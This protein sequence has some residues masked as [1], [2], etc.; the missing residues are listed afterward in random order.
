[1]FCCRWI[2]VLNNAK[3]AVL[4][5]A[6]GET[7]GSESNPINQSVKELT[8]TIMMEIKRL[9]GNKN[10]C[11]CGAIGMILA[12]IPLAVDSDIY[13]TISLQIYYI[14]NS[15]VHIIKELLV[16]ETSSKTMT[17]CQHGDHPGGL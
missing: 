16:R 14:N 1:M 5:K 7:S 17:C 12:S 6:F 2:S 4:L 9:P 3:E 13:L 10:C 15:F 11:D 8:G